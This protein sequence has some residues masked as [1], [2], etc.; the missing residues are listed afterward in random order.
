MNTY[1][2][3]IAAACILF[4]FIAA[5][6]T[7]P[8]LIIHYRKF[9]GIPVIRV[10]IVYS[11]ILYMMCALFLTLLPLPTR[12]EVAAMA[13]MP[14]CFI[15]FHDIYVG[16]VKAGFDFSNLSTFRDVSLWKAFLTSSDLFVVVMNVVM[17]IPLGIY[18]RY[19]FRFDFKKT[20][21]AG[22]LLSLFFEITQYTGIYGFYDK[23][24]RYAEVDDLITNTLGARIG[25]LITPIPALFLPKREDID[26]MSYE[27]AA[28][29]TV[30]KRITA[31]AIDLLLMSFLSGMLVFVFPSGKWLSAAEVLLWLTYFV[32][33]PFLWKD[34]TLGQKVVKVRVT[35]ERTGGKPGVIQFFLRNFILFILER[36]WVIIGGGCL[37]GLLFL[38]A[39]GN[40]SLNFSSYLA[41]AILRG[42]PVVSFII[43]LRGQSKHGSLP[44]AF[45]S[46]TRV[47]S[48]H[49]N[50]GRTGEIAEAE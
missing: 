23:R 30:F 32:F 50:I 49:E 42:V 40:L 7:L 43:L 45:L 31:D 28:S 16:L 26:R 2:S 15:P 39:G 22:L 38:L 1:V 21:L 13:P 24:Y 12:R 9:G 4:P 20:V 6:F 5:V 36:I 46:K 25:Y 11:F 34:S 37:A 48:V 17:T 3:S 8:F 44:H 14:P 33:L 29:V 10:M 27:G 18:L 35:D 47:K 41:V 19:Y